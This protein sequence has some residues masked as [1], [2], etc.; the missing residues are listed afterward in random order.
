[1]KYAGLFLA[2]F[3]MLA[4]SASSA[5]A[6]SFDA[7]G[8]ANGNV[9]IMNSTLNSGTHNWSKTTADASQIVEVAFYYHNNG[10]DTAHNVRISFNQPGSGNLSSFSF[11]GTLTADNASQVSDSASV[12]LNGSHTLT[13]NGL[14]WSVVNSTGS[15]SS[16]N[17]GASAFS[18]GYLIGDVAPNDYGTFSVQ[19]LV[20]GNQVVQNPVVTTNSA[21]GVSTNG[22]TLNGNV[23]LNGNQTATSYFEYSSNFCPTSSMQ[24]HRLARRY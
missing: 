19:F 22:A 16:V 5:D 17:N 18:G 11:T 6:A 23:S 8:S 20:G 4:L 21:T 15:G 7:A 9:L 3:A 10:S 14:A 1:M 13:Y 12:S 24:G 2:M